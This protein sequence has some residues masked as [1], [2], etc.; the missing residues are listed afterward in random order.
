[1][2]NGATSFRQKGKS[3]RITAKY[4]SAMGG[5]GWVGAKWWSNGF[6]NFSFKGTKYYRLCLSHS[7]MPN[8]GYNA[9]VK[10]RGNG[11][12]GLVWDDMT[13]S[14]ANHNILAEAVNGK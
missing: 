9:V 14:G 13:T 7:N 11:W 5:A 3:I 8:I 2:K 1:M 12:S 10:K 4:A 6:Y